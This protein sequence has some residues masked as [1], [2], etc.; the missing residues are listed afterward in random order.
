VALRRNVMKQK[1]VS[2]G[3]PIENPEG[4]IR[5]TLAYNDETM[6]CYFE[7][8]KGARIPLHNHPAVQT[9]YL[10]SG[11][12]QFLGE[13]ESDAF[14]VVPGDAYVFDSGKTHG[15]VALED[16][17]FVEVFAP[18]RDEYKDF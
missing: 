13:Q 8:E 15:G 3:K 4:V 9:G 1:S 6:L 14:E 5:R 12:V 10:I 11:H 17:V 18:S 16:S 7:L 2:T